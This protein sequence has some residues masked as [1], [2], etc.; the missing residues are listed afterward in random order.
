M[1][2]SIVELAAA[3]EID[4]AAEG[5]ETANQAKVLRDLGC[6]TLQGFLFGHP[7]P[8]CDMISAN[9]AGGPAIRRLG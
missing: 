7:A 3:L 1:V 9:R 5:V 2:R 4:V 6:Q 8:V